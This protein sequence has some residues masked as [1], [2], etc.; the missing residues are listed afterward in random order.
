[1]VSSH[2]TNISF[3]ARSSLASVVIVGHGFK[4]D[5]IQY[6]GLFGDPANVVS[7]IEAGTFVYCK[8]AENSYSYSCE[9][10]RIAISAHSASDFMPN[11]LIEAANTV[12]RD[13]DQVRAQITVSAIGL[14]FDGTTESIRNTDSHSGSTLCRSMFREEVIA[15]ITNVD[16]S[17]VLT[18]ATF[19]WMKNGLR[20]TIRCEPE[21]KSKGSN[22]IIAT[23]AQIMIDGHDTLH[24]VM[25]YTSLFI[26]EMEAICERFR[27]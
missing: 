5:M 25:G 13:L 16:A 9:P 14:N 20:F 21:E 17:S 19:S 3:N 22:L 7:T 12:A 4:P 2:Q 27:V 1:M 8:F 26:T 24:S 10:G 11:E 18:K 23:N 6:K 15:S